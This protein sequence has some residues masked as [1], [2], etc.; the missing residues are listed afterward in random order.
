VSEWAYY[1]EPDYYE[2]VVTGF[3]LR[4][5]ADKDD[6]DA[7]V[8]EYKSIAYWQCPDCQEYNETEI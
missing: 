6:V 8:Q 4:C 7:K 5:E 3:C 2:T 1:L